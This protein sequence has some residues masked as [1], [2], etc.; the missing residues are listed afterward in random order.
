MSKLNNFVITTNTIKEIGSYVKEERHAKNISQ[1]SIASQLKKKQ[2][3]IS[4]LENKATPPSLTL[5]TKYL[6]I[7]GF[8]IV[9]RKKK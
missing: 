9:I 2:S 5:L 6:S 8:E 3:N 7:L 4:L 1:Y